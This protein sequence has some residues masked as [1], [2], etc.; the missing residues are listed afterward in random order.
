M[1][2]LIKF[3]RMIILM[4]LFELLLIQ[5]SFGYPKSSLNPIE[6]VNPLNTTLMIHQ[7]N[8]HNINDI[9]DTESRECMR[10]A[11]KHPDKSFRICLK[12]ALNKWER[13][14][15]P[16]PEK[17]KNCCFLWSY[18]NCVL[19]EVLQKCGEK[20]YMI[21]KEAYIQSYNSKYDCFKFIDAQHQC[22]IERSFLKHNVLLIVSLSIFIVLIVS[23]IVIFVVV[24]MRRKRY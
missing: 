14:L 18:A 2:V 15:V 22:H 4:V 8:V 11:L 19:F 21:R 24:K 10:L 16:L 3:K 1:R 12:D 6:S 5:S 7:L 13:S 9:N 20:A 17:K 23:I